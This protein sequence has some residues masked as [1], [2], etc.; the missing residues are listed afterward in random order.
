MKN[1]I[2]K[3]FLFIG[4]LFVGLGT[5]HAEDNVFTFKIDG[6]ENVKPGDVFEV[7]VS[8]K[9]PSEEYTLTGYDIALSYDTNKLTLEGATT[10]GTFNIIAENAAIDE[11]KVL[12][13]LRFTV[14]AN[15]SAEATKLELK[16]DKSTIYKNGDIDKDS[17]FNSGTVSIRAI[18]TDSSLK[19]LKIPNTV[20]SPSFDKNVHDYTATVTDVTS[21][22]IKA[23]PN[24]SHATV[25]VNEAA[26]NLVKG[27]NDVVVVCTA[28]NGTQT[29]YVIKVT[30]NVTPTAE[31]LKAADVTLKSLTIK[32]QKIEFSPTEK[33]YYVNVDY[34]TTKLVINALPTN[35]KAEVTITG[36]SKFVVG[37]NTI[38]INVVSEDKTQ[39][40]TYQIIVTRDEE[41]KELVKTCPEETSKREWIVFTSSLLLTF[42]LG[43]V[44]GYFLCRKEVFK[45]LFKKKVKTEEPVEIETLSDTIDLSDTVK[46][47]KDEN[48]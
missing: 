22:D 26:G 32:G 44:L 12:V 33:K 36:N 14:N 10:P 9:G 8:V 18:G 37:K 40:D 39:N 16:K 2:I 43:I 45:K 15:A 34:D 17:T 23:E 27:D 30:L 41:E 28:E 20:L 38:K 3:L 25:A 7:N 24:E 1:R 11:E 21:I 13:T 35:E 47:T 6:K 48:K 31:E 46:Q 4:L 5:A 42:T 19:S 29:T